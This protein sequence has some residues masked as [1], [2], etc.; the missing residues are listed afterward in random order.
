MA[1]RSYTKRKTAYH[2]S[3]HAVAHHFFPLAGRTKSITIETGRLSEYNAGKHKINQAAGVH[4][5]RATIPSIVGRSVDREHVH[6]QLLALLAGPAAGYLYAGYT[7]KRR[8]PS[9]AQL[10]EALQHEDGGDDH[11]RVLRLL[12]DADPF[13]ARDVVGQIPDHDRQHL[14]PEELMERYGAPA[15]QAEG[16]RVLAEMARYER[17]AFDFVASKWPHIQA[18]ADALFRKKT[19]DGD[20][21]AAVIEAVEA[22]LR[23]G[24]PLDLWRSEP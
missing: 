10:E 22:R 18:L 4:F 6:H 15:V 20:E 21:V 1:A 5:S 13:D 11:T 24:P 17:E 7:K 8:K 2:E 19:L 23:K 9:K 12:Y 14:S 3:G 16:D